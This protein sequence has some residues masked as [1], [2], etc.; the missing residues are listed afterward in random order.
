MISLLEDENVFV[1]AEAAE[2]LGRIGA[3][4]AYEALEKVASDSAAILRR[5]ACEALRKLRTS[6]VRR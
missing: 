5:R 2:A 6:K 1:A 4:A 3:P